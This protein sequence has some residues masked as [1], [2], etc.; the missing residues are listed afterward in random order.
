MS[1]PTTR[2]L[3]LLE[4]LQTHGHMS[5]SAL[6]E[7]LK[8]DVRTVRRYIC[9]LEE[10]GIPITTEQGRYGGYMLVPGF[11]LP[12][13][14]FT[15]A[16]A[17]ALSLGLQAA[18]QMG[19][20]EAEPAVASVR[21]KLERVMPDKLKRRVRI[22]NENIDIQLPRRRGSE[23]NPALLPL[24]QAMQAQH[25]VRFSYRSQQGDTTNRRLDPYGLVYR[26]GRWYLCGYCHLRKGLRTFRLDR[27]GVL[28]PLNEEFERPADFDAADYINGSITNAW[29]R[30]PV[31]VLL[32]ADISATAWLLNDVEVMLEQTED[33]LLLNTATESYPYFAAWLG[34][35]P[36]DFTIIEPPQLQQAL[37][38]HARRLL[39]RAESG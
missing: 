9:V 39:R 27:L 14:M 11:K 16:E 26:F 34:S 38:E 35:L 37:L 23:N 19:L 7:C 20:D 18:R 33:G 5:G 21:A 36:F 10:L 4:L 22:A 3:A 1:N 29:R 31:T 2:V 8:V 30:F 12:P 25:R 15:D 6:A 17:L 28:T 32:H 13:M 24:T